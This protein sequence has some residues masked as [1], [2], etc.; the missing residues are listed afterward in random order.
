MVPHMM[1]EQKLIKIC[2]MSLEA[3]TEA[4]NLLLEFLIWEIEF[5]LDLILDRLEAI[6]LRR[7]GHGLEPL[8]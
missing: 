8:P 1:E 7:L 2:G 6:N 3:L 4:V 5:L